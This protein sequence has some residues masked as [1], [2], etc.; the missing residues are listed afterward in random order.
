[1]SPVNAQS[2]LVHSSLTTNDCHLLIA[3]YTGTLQIIK[4]Q[5]VTLK[6]LC[7]L[8]WLGHLVSKVSEHCITEVQAVLHYRGPA[9]PV[10]LAT[11]T[12]MSHAHHMHFVYEVQTVLHYRGPAD[13]VSLVSGWCLWGFSKCPGI[14][15]LVNPS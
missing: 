2:T 4:K 7:Q 11:I 9:Y 1:V 3:T 5:N 10:V 13:P 15:G 12:C 14:A 6:S 8:G